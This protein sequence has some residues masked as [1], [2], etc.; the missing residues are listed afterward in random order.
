MNIKQR[1]KTRLRRRLRVGRKIIGVPERPRL[2][3][4]RS[5]RHIYVQIV[6]DIAGATLASASTRSRSLRDQLEKTGNK[7][8]AAA[9]GKAIAKQAKQVGIKC[10]KFDRGCYRHHGRVKTLA[11]NAREAGLVF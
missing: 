1:Q 8:A 11:D 3:V 7:D 4:F 2:S 5:N 10:V 6:D 9:V